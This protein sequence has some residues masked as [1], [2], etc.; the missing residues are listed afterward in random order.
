MLQA[1]DVV[2]LAVSGGADSVAML[3]LVVT[4]RGHGLPHFEA[5]VAHLHHGIRG[6][7]ADED[8]AFAERLAQSLGLP[9]HL[10]RADVPHL[11]AK[12]GVGIEEAGRRLRYDFLAKVAAQVG[13][14]RV[15][16]G[17][18]ADDNVET[19][20]MRVARGMTYR[21]LAGIP[22]VR[23]LSKGSAVQVIRPM[24][25]CRRAEILGYLS[26][27]AAAWR[28]DSTNRVP[29]TLRNRIRR[30]VLPLL[31]QRLAPGVTDSILRGILTFR[32]AQARLARQAAEALAGGP[33]RQDQNRTSLPIGWLCSMPAKL[34]SEVIHHVLLR[35]IDDPDALTVRHHEAVLRMCD[36]DRTRDEVHLPQGVIARRQY[37]E[38][39]ILTAG[40]QEP[41]VPVRVELVACDVRL[42]GF[43]GA[44]SVQLRT[45][46]PNTLAEFLDRRTPCTALLDADKLQGALAV[47]AWQ[48][49][50]RM[51]PLGG[52]GARK[53]QDIFTDLKVPRGERL[54]TPILT[55]DGEP[56]WVAGCC[57]A[58]RAKVDAETGRV[59]EFVF[60]P[61]V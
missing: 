48:P 45:A 13:A 60:R 1:D 12:W 34:R 6:A 25:D 59:A 24:I 41:P 26:E 39:A 42:P 27:H 16:T 50:D 58:E 22:P 17:H 5:H 14:S 2:L 21:A 3:R 56:V 36:S 40:P 37:H 46:G 4:L 9:F 8:A 61:G 52:P 54:R 44:L 7:E 19:V 43:G 35:W 53:L 29:D 18:H 47:R 38:I 32:A 11:A 23:P 55:L 57:I 31:E 49:G 33:V 51:R 10:E 28:N 20:L 30:Q 15:A